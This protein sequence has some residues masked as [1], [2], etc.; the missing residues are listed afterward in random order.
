[1]DKTPILADPSVLALEKITS[2]NGLITLIFKTMNSKLNSPLPD[3]LFFVAH[4][5]V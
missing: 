4:N 5:N 2:E 1:M 3:K